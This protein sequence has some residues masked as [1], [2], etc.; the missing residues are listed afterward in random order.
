VTKDYTVLGSI[1]VSLGC[2]S[3]KALQDVLSEQRV[4]VSPKLGDILVLK[5]LISEEQ[6]DHALRLQKRM[7]GKNNYKKS[8]AVADMAI[9]RHRRESGIAKRSELKKKVD[10]I[11]SEYPD[12][13]D[14]LDK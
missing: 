9:R 3:E 13:T 12:L 6:L 11:T 4:T 10:K 2:I 5:G 8:I 1:L 14:Q 7:R